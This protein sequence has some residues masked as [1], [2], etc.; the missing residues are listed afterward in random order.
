MPRPS[1]GDENRSL[2]KLRVR[3]PTVSTVNL[4]HTDFMIINLRED[5]NER[6]LVAKSRFRMSNGYDTYLRARGEQHLRRFPDFHRT[7]L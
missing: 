5:M 4:R 2:P 6:L 7:S 1:L 3:Q